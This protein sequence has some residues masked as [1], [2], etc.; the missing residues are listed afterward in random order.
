MSLFIYFFQDFKDNDHFTTILTYIYMYKH[1]F[2]S[3]KRW[4]LKTVKISYIPS[5]SLLYLRKYL[6]N[7]NKDYIYF[8]DR[9][10]LKF[11]WPK[12]AVCSSFNLK[13]EDLHFR[14]VQLQFFNKHWITNY[15][16]Y[17]NL[18]VIADNEKFLAAV[19]PD[20]SN[21]SKA[22]ITNVLHE[23]EKMI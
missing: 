16:N 20:F 1:S 23:K 6:F 15:C 21:K 2:F 18:N 22:M 10:G 4:S 8:R 13:V 7:Q 14:F 11:F 3:K 5:H 9:K 19:K 12:F 17:W